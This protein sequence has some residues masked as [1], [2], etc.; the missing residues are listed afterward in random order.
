LTQSS[1]NV[2]AS[3]LCGAKIEAAF[4]DRCVDCCQLSV[5]GDEQVRDD[6]DA[7]SY[8]RIRGNMFHK[9]L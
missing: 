7:V 2:C 5:R 8:E 4:P 3:N 9:S 1:F 6:A